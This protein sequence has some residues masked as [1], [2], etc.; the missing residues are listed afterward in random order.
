MRYEVGRIEPNGQEIELDGSPVNFAVVRQEQE[1]ALCLPVPRPRQG[2]DNLPALWAPAASDTPAPGW[3]NRQPPSVYE[4]PLNRG[5]V[6]SH[7][8]LDSIYFASDYS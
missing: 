1:A 6:Y 2:G 3:E 7:A 4:G 5:Q 8:P